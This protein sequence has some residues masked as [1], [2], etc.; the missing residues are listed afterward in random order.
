MLGMHRAGVCLATVLALVA[1][2]Q[3]DDVA[4]RK[5][6]EALAICQ[7]DD[8]AAE[9]VV[10][11]AA[12][13]HGVEAAETAIAA[14]PQNARAHL[15][16][17]CTLGKQ[18]GIAGISWRSLQRL[19]RL[20]A[21]IDRALSLGPDDADILVA[22]GEMLRQL[23]SALGGDRR[24]AER[25]FRRAIAADPDHVA[26]RLFLAEILVENDSPDAEVAVTHAL[27]AAERR[28]TLQDRAAARALAGRRSD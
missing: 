20:K 1:T 21:T 7:Q 5:T 26:G 6:Q 24:A 2:A 23:P 10:R 19:N 13:D 11:L 14:D 9:K 4:V 3:A 15:A 17:F 28:G 16:L 12:L 27:E 8:P 18:Q 25:F 22:K